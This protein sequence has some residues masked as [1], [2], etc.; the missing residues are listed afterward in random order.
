MTPGFY[1][2]RTCEQLTLYLH[3]LEAHPHREVG[4]PVAETSHGDGSGA[5]PLAEELRHDEPGDGA[6]AHLEER[7]EA[8]NGPHADVGHPP[9]LVLENT[10]NL[11]ILPSAPDEHIQD[12]TSSSMAT[13]RTTA[14]SAIP[15]RPVSCSGLLPIRSTR[16]S[17]THKQH[18][19]AGLPGLDLQA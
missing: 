16:N 17:C 12:L 11:S 18:S 5:G 19:G 4:R 15:S 10:H 7:H 1:R 13:V 9:E 14:D 3:V 8:E 6:G 2:E